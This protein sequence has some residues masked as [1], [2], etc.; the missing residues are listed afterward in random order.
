MRPIQRLISAGFATAALATASVPAFAW[1]AWPDVDFEWYA[2]VGKPVAA[3]VVEIEPAPRAGSIWAP[4]HWERR[5]AHAQWVGA[6]WV[7]DDY[8]EQLAEYGRPAQYASVAPVE[9]AIT[10]TYP[11]DTN[12]R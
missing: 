10:P 11:I 8:M 4:A 3:N 1:T 9:G 2:N 6:H 12:R 5:G 7:R